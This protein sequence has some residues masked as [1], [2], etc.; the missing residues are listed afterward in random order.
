MYLNP[1]DSG[2]PYDLKVLTGYSER[3][4]AKKYYTLSGKGL[5]LYEGDTPVEFLS[6][7]QWLIERDSYNYIKDMSFFKQFKRWKFMRLWKKKI[8]H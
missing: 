1:S 5:T 8:K 4:E 3:D 2:D 7:G 6:L